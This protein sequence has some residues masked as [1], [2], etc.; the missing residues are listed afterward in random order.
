M[1]LILV[2]LLYV[3]LVGAIYGSPQGDPAQ[4]SGEDNYSVGW[5]QL[6]EMLF[7][8]PLWLAVGGLLLSA[9]RSGRMPVWVRPWGVI[10]YA[11]AVVTVWGVS[12]VCI[13]ADGG[14]SVIVPALLPPLIAGYAAAMRLPVFERLPVDSV[15]GA[16]LVAGAIVIAAAIPLGILDL[17]N[18]P[19]HVAADQRRMDAAAAQRQAEHDKFRAEEEARF[20]TLTPGS[21]LKDYLDYLNFLDLTDA[22]ESQRAAALDGLRHVKSRQEDAVQL[23]D[24]GSYQLWELWKF[25][26]QATPALC[27][28]FDRALLKI[29]V[30]DESY[31]L[32][33]VQLIK[34]QLPNIK[35]FVAGHCNLNGS[36]S[37]ATARVQKVV[38]VPGNQE[39]ADLL[40]TLVALQKS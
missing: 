19:A 33:A 13:A 15:S 17:Q 7:G 28:A 8:I 3:P 30:G 10:L 18:L 16:A 24:E 4:F 34:Y 29:A 31:D 25:D 32:N 21:P 36:L 1:L 12:Q 5:I 35:F 27:A 14:V 40:A 39:W 26:L 37:A 9:A 2:C 11:A 6:W 23:L 22:S 20:K 38:A